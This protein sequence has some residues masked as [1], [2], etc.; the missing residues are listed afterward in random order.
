M[1]NYAEVSHEE[2]E[3][4]LFNMER[5]FQKARR[6]LP[7]DWNSRASFDRVLLRLDRTSSP[8]WPLMREQPT[9]GKWLF[10]DSLHPNP[11]R[12]NLL[13]HMVQDVLRGEF[14]HFYKVF[15]KCEP[16]KLEKARQGR[17]RLI[18]MSSLPYQ[19]VWHMAISHLETAF[20][21]EVG[22][23]P[24]M[25]A[26]VYYGGG[27]KRFRHIASV[28]RLRWC[29][30]KSGWDWN[31][32]GWV[33]HV[34]CELRKRLTDGATPE[35]ELLLDRLYKDAYEESTLILPTGEVYQQQTSG[36]MKSGLVP[37]ISDNGL[38]QIALHVRAELRLGVP[39]TNIIATGDDTMQEIPQDP[40]AY[41]SELQRGGCVVKEYGIGSDFMGFDIHDDGFKP[42]YV[43]KHLV[44]LIYQEDQYLA[45]TLESYAMMYVHRPVFFD[46]WKLVASKLG[47][48]LPSR[49]YFKYFA[50]N[51]DVFETFAVRKPSFLDRVVGVNAVA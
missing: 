21:Q 8:G 11:I 3:R 16:H 46:Y 40:E 41:L 35:W 19:V 50:D 4:V 12:A 10:G 33:F 14:E 51:P 31:A 43:A 29:S 7:T 27:W 32:P 39:A 1:S 20:L 42:R 22:R 48:S 2:Q 18:I 36:L 37:T 15:I 25:H 28:R 30:D 38:A 17:W 44:N 5:M 9:I 34:C 26:F 24:L 45:E 6:P 49:Q 23:T 13:W 47:V